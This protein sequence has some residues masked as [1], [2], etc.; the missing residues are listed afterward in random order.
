MK[1]AI[2]KEVV[3]RYSGAMLYRTWPFSFSITYVLDTYRTVSNALANN[4]DEIDDEWDET[5]AK[6][7]HIVLVE[8]A[9][10]RAEENK[11]I[12]SQR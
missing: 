4:G 10:F 5:F 9:Q 11:K 12:R 1:E 6:M 7:A 8:R 2:R 3:K